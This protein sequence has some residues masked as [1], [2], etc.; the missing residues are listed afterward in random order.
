MTDPIL[1]PDLIKQGLGPFDSLQFL[2]RGT[3]GETYQATRGAETFA[4]KVIHH[5]NLP[6]FLW[7]REVAALKATHHPNIVGFRKSGS[8][9]AGGKAYLF[10]ECE[11]IAGG[12][13]SSRIRA[14]SRPQATAELKAFAIGLL[15]GVRELQDLGIL[16]RDI[17]PDNVALRTAGWD[18]PVLLD[19][20]LARVLD[21]SAHTV[22]PT[23][24]GT[25]AYMAPEQLRGE[26][27]RRRSDL[28]SAGIVIYEAGTGRHPFLTPQIVTFEQLLERMESTTP[29]DPRQLSNAFDEALA[30]VVLRLLSF[31]EHE[32]LPITTALRELE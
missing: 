28:Y 27:A 1:G 29:P 26:P 10:L 21:M 8:F 2:G 24:V 17:K 13:V 16:H 5:P 32:R 6:E 30:T 11:F 4:L 31:R 25:A 22:Y 19:F 12:A 15:R 23:R 7:K 14:G 18:A 9:E 20:G 3:Y